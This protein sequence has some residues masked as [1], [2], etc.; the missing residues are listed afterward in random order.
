MKVL[1]ADD[2]AV[3]RKLLESTLRRW[4]Y[5]V[6]VACDGL[7]AFRILQEVDAPKLAILDWLMPG[8]DGVQICR[9]IRQL[10]SEPYTYI[11]LLTGKNT[12]YDVIE[13]LDAG[14]DDYVIKPYDARELQV[15][16]RTGKRILYLQEQLIAARET[17]RDQAT[18][19]ALTGLWNRAATFEMLANELARQQRHGGSIG[20]VLVD[21]DRF[22]LINDDYGHL[23]GDEALRSA[24]K[25]MQGCTRRYDAVGRF[26]GEEFI[27]VL[28]GCDSMNALSHAERMRVAIEQIAIE[29]PR[30]PVGV[31]ASLGVAVACPDQTTDAVSLIRAAD[32]ALYQAKNNGRNRVE[33]ANSEDFSAASCS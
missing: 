28:P 16:L 18:H 14:A 11:L 13:G 25:A 2:E 3:S 19:D 26:G 17:L 31:T 23:I 29:T 9:E 20:V 21:L 27:L 4:G 30:G 7:E 12:K 22:K 33:F 8:L 5:E 6:V 1:V 15:R 10:R 24:A 32:A